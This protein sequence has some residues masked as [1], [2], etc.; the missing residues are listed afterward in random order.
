M[1]TCAPSLRWP[2]A[3]DATEHKK[4]IQTIQTLRDVAPGAGY[5]VGSSTELNEAMSLE[6]VMGMTEMARGYGRFLY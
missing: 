1:R 2:N 5:C 4:S 3:T 6:N